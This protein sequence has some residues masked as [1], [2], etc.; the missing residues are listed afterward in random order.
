[1]P[2]K[3]KK[4][5]LPPSKPS[6]AV[7]HLLD[8]YLTPPAAACDFLNGHLLC[9]FVTS[10]NRSLTAT[11]EQLQLHIPPESRNDARSTAFF[12][13]AKRL[14]YQ[15]RLTRKVTNFA[16]FCELC[17]G[18]FPLLQTLAESVNPAVEP[19]ELMPLSTNTPS[20]DHVETE[21]ERAPLQETGNVQQP[22]MSPVKTRQSRQ[23]GNCQPLRKSLT[24]E[25]ER[26][27]TAVKAKKAVEAKTPIKALRN[28]FA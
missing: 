18:Q 22:A 4:R 26:R 2:P 9:I 23:C 27:K 11:V 17:S 14:V 3:P 25:I 6:Q 5:C 13:D 21:M 10:A 28:L 15:S 12:R 8:N 16:A 1:M 7:Q 19:D 20:M 24:H